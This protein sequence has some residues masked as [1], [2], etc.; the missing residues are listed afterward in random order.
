[1]P[2][3]AHTKAP[4]RAQFVQQLAALPEALQN[5]LPDAD[6]IAKKLNLETD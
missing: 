3:I 2:A 1:M 5:E 6:E 4:P